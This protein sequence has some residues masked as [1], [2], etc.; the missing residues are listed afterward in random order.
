MREDQRFIDWAIDL[1]VD[2]PG[3]H[4]V[5]VAILNDV[6]GDTVGGLYEPQ[7]DRRRAADGLRTRQCHA[8]GKVPSRGQAAR[9]LDRRQCLRNG[10]GAQHA[11]E[12]TREHEIDHA[13]PART[14]R[15]R[16]RAARQ[17]ASYC[18]ALVP[19]ADATVT[20][21]FSLRKLFSPIPRTFMRSSTFLKPPLFSRY[22]RIRSAVD[23]PMP[24]SVSN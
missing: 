24:G 1:Q 23:L 15:V 4:A 12:R 11:Q 22:S 3:A 9:A 18:S 5:P 10:D 7:R 21:G 13:E 8:S 14:A 2:V 20:S 16:L 17:H 6:D 19:F